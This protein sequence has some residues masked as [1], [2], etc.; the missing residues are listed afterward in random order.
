ML[1]RMVNLFKQ[2][3]GLLRLPLQHRPLLPPQL[4]H[5]PPLRQPLLL[6]PLLL[7]GM[8][9][10]AGLE[11]ATLLATSAAM[12]LSSDQLATPLIIP[13]PTTTRTD[14]PFAQRV[15]MLVVLLATARPATPAPMV[16]LFKQP[17]ELR[18]QPLLP[19]QPLPPPLQP[20][21]PRPQQP[22]PQQPHQPGM[23]ARPT[24]VTPRSTAVMPRF[25]V[26][27]TP[28][29]PRVCP[30]MGPC[31]AVTGIL[32]EPASAPRTKLVQEE[33]DL[34]L[35]LTCFAVSQEPHF[36][37]RDWAATLA[38]Q[39]GQFAVGLTMRTRGVAHQGQLVASM[40]ANAMPKL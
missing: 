17:R 38:V 23:P 22:R 24:A 33:V 10:S 36:A 14:L 5:P 13:A 34:E 1:V 25:A 39:L 19:P 9:F 20:P 29:F 28:C 12:M 27:K 16:N 18:L 40:T 2:R 32:L 11:L 7:Q 15:L 30:L 35:P 4:P 31:N 6:L 26:D 3:L 21:Q 37:T 8:E